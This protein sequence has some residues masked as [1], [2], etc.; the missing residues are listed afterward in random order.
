MTIPW[1]SVHLSNIFKVFHCVCDPQLLV[2]LAT[3]QPCFLSYENLLL[4]EAMLMASALAET[5]C[6]QQEPHRAC[7]PAEQG[8]CHAW[9]LSPAP[10]LPCPNPSVCRGHRGHSHLGLPAAPRSCREQPMLSPALSAAERGSGSRGV[11]GPGQGQAHGP[12]ITPG[13][14]SRMAGTACV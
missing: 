14:R 7:G 6:S 9:A 2:S 10:L 13:Q 3:A 1:T 8:L 11:W 5:G 4:A 12:G